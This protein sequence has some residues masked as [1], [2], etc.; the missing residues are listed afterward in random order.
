[1]GEPVVRGVIRTP[2]GRR[3]GAFRG[4]ESCTIV[5]RIEN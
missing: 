4:M 3:D 2:F 1:M 5:E